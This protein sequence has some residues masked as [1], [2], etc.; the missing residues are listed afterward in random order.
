VWLVTHWPEVKDRQVVAEEPYPPQMRRLSM[1]CLILSSGSAGREQ[2]RPVDGTK[3]STLCSAIYPPER[4]I[5][6][7][8]II[9]RV[10]LQ[11]LL[12]LCSRESGHVQ[13]GS[14][15]TSNG[16]EEEEGH[17]AIIFLLLLGT[18]LS[19]DLA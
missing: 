17:P 12:T 19:E 13:A 9:I 10:L 3:T 11:V 15:D 16:Q 7:M 2:D 6:D 18:A 14:T 1:V 5:P 4:M 8:K